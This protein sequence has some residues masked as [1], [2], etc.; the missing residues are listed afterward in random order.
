MKSLP[1]VFLFLSAIFFSRPAFP[2]EVSPEAL[3]SPVASCLTT[4]LSGA[5]APSAEDA[6]SA[7][8]HQLELGLSLIAATNR[9]HP[10]FARK[11]IPSFTLAPLPE[12]PGA[13][14]RYRVVWTPVEN[15]G[16]NAWAV[17]VE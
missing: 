10:M 5:D 13:K 3:V 4:I 15:D 9:T 7:C 16:E 1:A 11:V 6:V 12:P 17:V 14:A 2:E 8:G